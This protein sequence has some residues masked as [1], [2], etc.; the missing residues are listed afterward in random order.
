[1]KRPTATTITQ[2]AVA[3]AFLLLQ[4]F[5]RTHNL[6]VQDPYLDE[7]F[8][9]KR[10]AVVWDFDQ[11][12]GRISRG[13]VLLYF[14]LGLFEADPHIALPVSRAAVAVFSLITGAA[15]YAVGRRLGGHRAGALALGLYAVL[16][17]AFFYERMAMAAWR[18]LSFARRPTLREGA[19]LGVLLALAIFSK[20]TMSLL[21]LLPVAA[22][23]IYF[24]WQ[25]AD[26]RAQFRRWLADYL[27]PLLVAAGVLA[28]CWLP[29]LIP[30]FLARNS[31][32]PFR[33][34]DSFNL[35][36]SGDD[37]ASPRLYIETLLPLVRD[38]TGRAF[39][40]AAGLAVLY[41][42]VGGWRTYQ[43]RRFKNTLFLAVWLL[44]F[45][46]L[47][48]FTARLITL[49]YY[50][51]SAGP[52]ALILACTAAG[53]WTVSRLRALVRA[54]VALGVGAWL[55]LFALPFA[56]TDLTAPD[57]LNLSGTNH[58]EYQAGYLIGD[59]AVRAAAAALNRAEPPDAAQYAT[60]WGCHLLY[61]YTDRPVECLGYGTPVGDLQ[62][63][64]RDDLPPGE[65]AYLA[66]TGYSFFLDRI[67]GL[68]WEAVAEYKHPHIN[69]D[70]W[71]VSIWRLWTGDPC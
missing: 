47:P 29:F 15:L 4:L 30:A 19:I 20:L 2:L 23:L 58:T 1:M 21:P 57:K 11:H 26:L 70:A 64:V 52:L 22:A 28:L 33:L 69:Y 17:L 49:R 42:L 46:L 24:P 8:H 6:T 36:S 68:C 34:V 63:H 48:V 41:G 12:P 43:H 50:M 51:T 38:V 37:P 54:G 55:I 45:A 44:L 40:I 14:W 53:L 7:G 39:L 65:V 59:E 16:P 66:V 61:F 31:D 13:K 62:Q 32:E 56:Y 10:A 27:P 3:A 71:N 60:W 25:R 5:I 67:D 35:R 18:S 9:I